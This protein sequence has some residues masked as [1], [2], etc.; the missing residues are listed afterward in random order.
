M[1]TETL[2]SSIIGMVLSSNVSEI[3]V[4][5]KLNWNIV[6]YFTSEWPDIPERGPRSRA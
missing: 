6:T 5:I 4:T 1:P 3:T 2:S